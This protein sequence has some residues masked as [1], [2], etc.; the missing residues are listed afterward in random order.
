[1]T[2]PNDARIGIVVLCLC[3]VGFL[4]RV[5][6]ALVREAAIARR[7]AMH[8]E[9]IT[10]KLPAQPRREKLIVIDAETLQR[11]LGA[12]AGSRRF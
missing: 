1:M 4:L 2:L 3:A 11:R 8:G 5:L 7:A 12:K 9:M 6:A 10:V